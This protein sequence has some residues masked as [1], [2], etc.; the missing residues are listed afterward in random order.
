M[1][2]AATLAR[3]VDAETSGLAAYAREV[4]QFGPLTAYASGAE[5]PTDGAMLDPTQPLSDA[6]LAQL[7]DFFAQQDIMSKVQTLGHVLPKSLATLSRAGLHLDYVLHLYTHNLH[8][9]NVPN[10]IHTEQAADR[11]QWAGVAAGAFGESSAAIM[12][13][14]AARAD[15]QCWWAVVD[16]QPAGVGA[17]TVDAGGVASLF[18]AATLP[19]YRARGVQSALLGARLHAAQ[20]QGAQIATVFVSPSSGS[21]R[22]VMR[23]GFKLS[24][25]RLNFA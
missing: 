4:Q 19:A 6:D 2:S 9:V 11:A 24:G 10:G 22:N 7:L 12:H 17:L 1:L 8:G 25:M 14:N 18:S 15:L 23:L 5:L 13:A 16:G 3:I 20:Q 21:E